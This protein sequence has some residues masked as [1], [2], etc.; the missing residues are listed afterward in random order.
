[1]DK[2]GVILMLLA[3]IPVFGQMDKS[4]HDYRI[5]ANLKKC[6]TLL[7]KTLSKEEIEVVKS[8][9]EDSIYF[10]D[11]FKHGTDFFHAWK[12]YDGS[13][14][15]RFFNRKGLSG[16]HEIYVT[17]LTS[18]H[19]YLNGEEIRL[20]EQVDKHQAIQK[21]NYRI[22]VEKTKKD[23][24]N[25]HYIPENVEDCLLTLNKILKEKD[26]E[27]LK[28]LKS[29]EDVIEFHHGLGT[30]LRNNWGL[31]GGSRLQQ[32][33][34]RKGLDHPDNMSHLI[35]EFYYDWLNSDNAGWREFDK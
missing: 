24:I 15:T 17:I 34:L 31:W 8:F 19:R 33:L 7:D 12:L 4:V 3:S 10:H 2:L 30:W 21:E 16:S 22:F 25:G 32:Y 6:Y 35:L 27:T 5:P 29:R 26:I 11:E 20:E 28:K 1:M 9:P 14:L 13:R 18:Y 23:T